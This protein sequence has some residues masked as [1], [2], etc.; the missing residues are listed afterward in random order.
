[1]QVG[2]IADATVWRKHKRVLG[3]RR[4]ATKNSMGLYKRGNI[5]WMDYMADG[6]QHL[7]STKET[8]RRLAQQKLDVRRAEVAQG[9]F[10]LLR[11]NGPKLG[12]WAAR[13]LESVQHSNTRRRYTCSKANLLSFFGEGA[14][15]AHISASRIT[16]FKRSRRAEG[17]KAATLNRDLRFLAQILKQAERERYIA[18]SPFDLNRF[19]LNE[20]PERR[21]PH[22]L[23]WEEQEKLLAVAPPR[24]RVLTVLGVETGMRT[25]EMLHLQW[26]DIDFLTNVLRIERSK[27]QSGIRSV[28][29]SDFCK[30]EL[31]RWRNLIGPEYSKW[32]FPSLS[33][34]RHKLQGGRKAW[35]SALGKAEIPFFPIY[36]LR[37]TFASRMTAAGVSPLTI[38]QMLGHSSTEIVPRYAQVLDQNR[39]DA[40]K[41]LESLRQASI[42]TGAAAETVQTANQEMRP[43]DRTKSQ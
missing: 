9:H 5:W 31:L 38:A 14:R 26:T 13:Y 11:K 18:R 22:I 21:K 41:K 36:N 29:I 34:R 30:L 7:E 33:N 20:A 4:A 24:I 37:H 16:E 10:N 2:R 12:D 35:A 23:T 40:M 25:G 32:L 42:S 17:I 43:V 1:M 19:F 6:A 27:T 28:P 39:F 8:N 3:R 15:L